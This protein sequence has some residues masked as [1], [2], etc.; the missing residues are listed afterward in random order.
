MTGIGATSAGADA[1]QRLGSALEAT[2]SSARLQAALAAGTRPRP[3][4]VPVLIARCGVEP[5]FSVREM[6]TWALVRY[7][8]S[9]TVP[10]LVSEVTSASTRAR[11]QA[12]H[13]LSKIADSAGWAAITP[14]VLRDPDD[15]VART[16]WRAAAI[17][18]PDAGAPQLATQLA[19]QLGRG[20]RDTR[21]S[22]TRSLAVLGEAAGPA[23]AQRTGVGVEP[24]IRMH[25]IATQRILADPDEG[26]DAAMFE[27]E[28]IIAFG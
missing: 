19:A 4:Y 6:L 15:E 14:E 25:A 11:A 16:A 20:Q 28:R 9:L 10:L 18:V 22:L 5:D 27:A 3:E 24:G 23:V 8:A 13:T 12:L 17:L 7:P 21:M 26:F 1:A 2:D